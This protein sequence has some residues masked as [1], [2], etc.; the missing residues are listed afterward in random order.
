MKIL[1]TGGAGYIGSHTCVELLNAGYDVVVVDNLSNSSKVALDRVAQITGKQVTFYEADVLDREKM[2][3]IFKKEN[4]DA[5]IHFAGLKAVGESVE[6]PLEYYTNNIAG[7]L[8][9]LDEMKKANVKNII[10]S[11]SATVYGTP[12]EIPITEKCP[13]GTCTNPYG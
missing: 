2:H 4:V 5:V 12:K 1:V 11:S 6:K 8:V 10:F 13:K 3:A 7:T 9:L